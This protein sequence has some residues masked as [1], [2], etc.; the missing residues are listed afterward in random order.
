MFDA[1]DFSSI[2]QLR[3]RLCLDFTNTTPYHFSLDEDHM[4]G[5]ADL[6]AWGVDEALLSADE[7]ERLWA[8][9]ERKP[10]AAA[11]V[12]RKAITLREALFRIFA[13]SE[14]DEQPDARDLDTFNSALAEAMTHMRLMPQDGGYGWE[15]IGD[16]DDLAQMLWPVAWSASEL[17]MSD[18]RERVRVCGG[19]DCEWLFVDTSRNHSRRWCDMTVCGNRAKAKR[20]YHRSRSDSEA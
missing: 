14:H 13:S 8:I 19:E 15:W 10:Q 6:L 9:A 12:F 3:E 1:F 18:E 17:L 5:Y 20:H 4:H 11:G 2:S 16:A 7:A